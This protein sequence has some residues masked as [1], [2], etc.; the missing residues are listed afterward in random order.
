MK[1]ACKYRFSNEEIEAIKEARRVNKDKRADARLKALE[2]RAEGVKGK[3]VSQATGFHAAYPSKTMQGSAKP[4][5]C[6]CDGGMPT[7]DRYRRIGVK[8]LYGGISFT[9]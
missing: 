5:N 9:E 3:E 8:L 6:A 4:V 1:I 7:A 2:L